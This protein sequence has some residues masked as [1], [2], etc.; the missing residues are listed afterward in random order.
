MRRGKPLDQLERHA[1]VFD[2]WQSVSGL[3]VPKKAQF[4][5][6]TGSDLEGGVLGALEYGNVHF[7]KDAPDPSKFKKAADAVLA[8]M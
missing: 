4:Y 2:E 6:W 8:P 3:L 5:K 7:L 1:I